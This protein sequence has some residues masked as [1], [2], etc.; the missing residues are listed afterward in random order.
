MEV[1]EQTLYD[2]EL[3]NI[4]PDGVIILDINGKI[5]QLNQQALTELHVHSS[6]NTMMPLPT[7]QIFKLLNNK[8]DILRK[9]DFFRCFRGKE[10]MRKEDQ[11]RGP[12][13]EKY[14]RV[15]KSTSL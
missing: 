10:K 13:G 11:V 14:I 12:P 6:V 2:D 9:E 15:G 4:L 7:S 1:N 3:L 5:I 8:E